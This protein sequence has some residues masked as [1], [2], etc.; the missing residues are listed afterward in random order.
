MRTDCFQKYIILGF[1]ILQILLGALSAAGKASSGDIAFLRFSGNFYQV[2]LMDADGS[3][4][5]QLTFSPGDKVNISWSTNGSKLLYNTNMGELFVLD[6]KTGKSAPVDIGMLGMTDAE[7]SPDGKSILFSLSTTD[8]IDT[9][10][11]WLVAIAEKS[12]RKVTRMAHLQHHPVWADQGRKILFLSGKGDDVHDIWLTDL[13]GRTP[14]QLTFSNGY[15]FEPDCSVLNQ[16]AFSSNRGG[17]YDLYS[18]NL[19]GANVKSMAAHPGFDSE[20]DWGPEGKKLIFVSN[21]SGRPHIWKVESDG[22]GLLQLTKGD[23]R[24]RTPKWRPK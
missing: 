14:Q 20:P 11:I 21:R 4:A 2:W 23:S 24:N 9:N 15:N 22:S 7:Y 6:L 18:M 13:G 5:R 17:N 8:S 10:D 12:R 1:V 19:D 16:I 3:N